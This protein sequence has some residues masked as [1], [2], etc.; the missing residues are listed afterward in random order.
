M[1]RKPLHSYHSFI[2]TIVGCNLLAADNFREHITPIIHLII[3][4]TLIILLIGLIQWLIN[5]P[6]E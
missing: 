5:G 1:R 6:I 3:P 2:A 4:I